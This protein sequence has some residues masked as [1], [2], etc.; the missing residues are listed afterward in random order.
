MREMEG[1]KGP[2]DY[3]TDE[4]SPTEFLA[5]MRGMRVVCVY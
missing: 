2:Q 3:A 4:D 5:S 1:N